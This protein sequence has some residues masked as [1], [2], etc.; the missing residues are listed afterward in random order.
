MA[1]VEEILKADVAISDAPIV[2]PAFKKLLLFWC[3][4]L[5]KF[6]EQSYED[7]EPGNNENKTMIYE[8]QTKT[9]AIGEKNIF[10]AI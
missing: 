4:I 3:F 2:V 10:D 9:K 1:S 8:N 6:V 5:L 7:A